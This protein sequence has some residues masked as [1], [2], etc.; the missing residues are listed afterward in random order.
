MHAFG[1]LPQSSVLPFVDLLVSHGGAGGTLAAL[2]HALPHLV[3]PGDGMSQITAA[4]AVQRLG[5]GLR[6]RV[7]E[8]DAATIAGAAG[9]LITDRRFA[10]AAR[11]LRARL[12]MLPGPPEV[13]EMLETRYM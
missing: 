11:E 12:D 4:E 7:G 9:E 5:I 13:V 8:R 2:S 3:L 6:L 10:D 1:Y